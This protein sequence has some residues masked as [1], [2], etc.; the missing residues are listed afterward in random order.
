MLKEL[1]EKAKKLSVLLVEDDENIR[2]QMERILKRFFQKVYI[3]EDGEKGLE[4]F[5]S[6]TKQIDLILTDIAM[7]NMNGLDMIQA[8]GENRYDQP[9]IMISAHN[10]SDNLL[11][12]I[13]VGVD[14]FIIKPVNVD[15]LMQVLHKVILEQEK[16][17][18]LKQLAK[19][20]I[21]N[22]T[23]LPNRFALSQ[24]LEE[25]NPLALMLLNIDFF[26]EV[27]NVYG[28]SNGD[29]LICEMARRI[30]KHVDDKNY[31]CYS[32]QGDEFVIL[33][34]TDQES[35]SFTVYS[36]AEEMVELI[37][38]LESE[39][40]EI[41]GWEI[42][43]NFTVG[44]AWNDKGDSSDLLRQADIALN[45]ARADNKK[46][47]IYK[48]NH[49]IFKEYENNI[50]W[51]KKIK[52]AIQNEGVL[53]YFQPIVDNTS[54]QITKYEC[55]V[56]LRDQD[57]VIHSPN[58]FLPIAKKTK[59]YLLIMKEVIRKA[60][61]CFRDSTS[62]FSINLSVEDILNQEM[63]EYIF[64][65]IDSHMDVAPRLIFEIL[66]SEGIDNYEQVIEFIEEVKKRGCKISV[67]DF[68]TGYSNFYHVI[69]LDVD[70]LKLDGTLIKNLHCDDNA[71]AVVESIVDFANKLNIKTVA[72]YVHCD[73]VQERVRQLQV[74]YSQGYYIGKP[75]SCPLPKYSEDNKIEKRSQ[76]SP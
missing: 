60:L 57:G 59:T 32:L 12:A 7:P 9:V 64:Q 41:E 1:K 20:S 27:N 42:F 2:M 37:K 43:R 11:R 58:V 52:E 3:A 33:L 38:K 22:V 44:I 28:F 55:L 34:E 46:W 5:N 76:S 23:G 21:D 14:D 73:E 51:L 56:R 75:E 4:L 16:E 15:K 68:G 36:C 8:M 63:R 49:S 53:L 50:H 61:Q 19:L 17:K 30:K 47:A 13:T 69:Q 71:K 35:D 26:K 48:E 70:Y 62:D 24:D 29:K 74:N 31:S 65:Q 40:F 18:K 39:P 10:D 45:Q 54:G 67:D 66:E 25:K 6:K 72:E